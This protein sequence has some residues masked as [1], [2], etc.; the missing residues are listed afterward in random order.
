METRE[1]RGDDP[2]R[3]AVE[4]DGGTLS[5]PRGG[6]IYIPN[7]VGP[8][9]SVAD[10]ESSLLLQLQVAVFAVLLFLR[11]PNQF[12]DFVLL[13]LRLEVVNFVGRS[14]SFYHLMQNL[15][16]VLAS[17]DSSPLC[18]EDLSYVPIAPCSFICT[19]ISLKLVT[20]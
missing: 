15:E 13:R 12:I 6:P 4:E 20:D 5:V 16:A 8:L 10:F 7:L 11:L 2:G 17:S 19:W 3:Q 1:E 14:R 9:T 18:G